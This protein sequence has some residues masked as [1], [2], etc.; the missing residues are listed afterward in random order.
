MY[1]RVFELLLADMRY[2]CELIGHAVWDN[3]LQ[4]AATARMAI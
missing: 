1:S 2:Q 3:D 4:D